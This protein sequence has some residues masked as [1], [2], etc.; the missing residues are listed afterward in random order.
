[1]KL[2]KNFKL[3]LLVFIILQIIFGSNIVNAAGYSITA[4]SYDAK[5]GDNV[6]INVSFTAAAWDIIVSGKGISEGV[7]VGYT[8]D[9]S[10]KTTSKSISLNT[11]A[12]GTYTI[13][14]TGSITDQNGEITKINKSITVKVSKPSSGTNN[15]GQTNNNNSSSSTGNST[16]S[17]TQTPVTPTVTKSSEARLSNFGIKPNDFSGFKKDKTEYSTT[18]QNSVAEVDVYAEPVD[19]KATVK[20]TGKV[21]LKEGDNTVKVTV[22]AEDGKTTKTYTLTIKRKTAAEE[23][24]E[25]GE[26]RLSELGIKPEK[27]DIS[28]FKS[29]QTEY[30]TEVPNEVE[31]IEVYAKAM[32]SKAQITGTGMIELEEGKNELKI[33]VIAQNGT[34]KTYTIEVTRK[35]EEKTTI[36]KFGLSTLSV[37]GLNLTPGFM[38]GTYEYTVDLAEDLSSLEI[39]AKAT[40]KDATVEIVGNENLQEGENTITI[41]VQNED[42][43]ES[44]TYQ[45]TVNK[46]LQKEEV[47][48]T[49]WLK[50]S[51]WGKEEKIKIAI[52]I[53]LIILII[54]AIVLKIKMAKE[55]E[56]KNKL[57]LPGADELDKAITE[58]QELA[59]EEI[60]EEVLNTEEIKK[61]ESNYIEEIARNRFGI[62]EDLEEKTK[63]RKGK[64]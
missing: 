2:K 64:H 18:V 30:A 4:T 7:Y 11:A 5:V 41:L 17:N 3:I 49:S 47:V 42:T 56:S 36:E 63:K 61:E 33:E 38:T 8:E 25:A 26:A 32:D 13:T 9:L 34:K 15:Q 21:S 31:E 54:S 52:I 1:M 22:T 45:I 10:E 14:M 40:D 59:S 37:K 19:S 46:N 62:E 48:Q 35:E 27:Y 39:E 28:G 43:E 12:E 29:E 24:A 44:A 6:T 57:D 20:G 51:T 50:P 60:S 23:E 53:V 58:H 16:N 55:K